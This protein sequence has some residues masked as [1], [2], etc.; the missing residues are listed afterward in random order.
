M[1]LTEVPHPPI[2]ESKHVE[3]LSRRRPYPF[4]LDAER[5]VAAFGV[6]LYN[7]GR[8]NSGRMADYLGPASASDL[9]RMARQADSAQTA[10]DRIDN[11]K[12]TWRD[13]FFHTYGHH[14]DRGH[15]MSH[16]QGGGLDINLFPQLADISRGR[17]P[18]G[19]EYRAMEKACVAK[20][21]VDPVFC[22]SRPIHDDDS[23]VPVELEYAVI[24]SSQRI[25]SRR[26][27]NRPARS[28]RPRR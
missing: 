1:P 12:Q 10:H 7:P 13:R 21:G 28:H 17:T 19:A 25:D 20:P 23:L 4:D 18:L 8:R 11:A 14:Y 24:H 15:F 2:A 26:F 27:P 5:V 9:Q 16:C 3:T 6:T 22:C